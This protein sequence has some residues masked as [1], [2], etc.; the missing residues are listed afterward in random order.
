VTRSPAVEVEGL[1]ALRTSLKRAGVSLQ[2]LKDAHATVAQIVVRAASPGAPRRTGALAGSTRGSGQAGA[3]VVRAGRASLPYAGPVHW[4][5]PDRHITAQPWIWDA[6]VAAQDQWTGE[7]LRA[8]Q[9]II[10]TIEG[11]SGP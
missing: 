9:Q 5:W 7:Y 11:T 3:A 1:R 10:D 8:L 2:D 4:G 6:A